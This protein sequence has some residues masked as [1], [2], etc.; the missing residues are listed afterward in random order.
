M[1]YRSSW[2]DMINLPIAE[3]LLGRATLQ[4]LDI[5]WNI[6]V[7]S[8]EL[9]SISLER[10]NQKMNAH[11]LFLLQEKKMNRV[12]A[13]KAKLLIFLKDTTRERLLLR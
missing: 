1:R 12:K 10:V 13:V 2:K 4:G 3:N 8:V 9:F 6:I 7:Q 11:K 5:M